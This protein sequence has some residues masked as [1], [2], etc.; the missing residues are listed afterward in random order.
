MNEYE[1]QRV[2]IQA[3]QL[4]LQRLQIF[5]QLFNTILMAGLPFITIY[6]NRL[7]K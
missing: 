7:L 2:A 6:L 4:K 3:D 1:K 5:I